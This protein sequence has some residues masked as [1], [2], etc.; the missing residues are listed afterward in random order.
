MQ[1]TAS[2]FLECSDSFTRE[3]LMSHFIC[4][5]ILQDVQF[6]SKYFNL[7]HW[8]LFYTLNAEWDSTYIVCNDVE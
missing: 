2:F 1:K 7:L 8:F 6:C 3:S 5:V 4:D